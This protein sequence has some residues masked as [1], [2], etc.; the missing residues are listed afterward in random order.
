MKEITLE[1][2]P[3]DL[4]ETA[5]TEPEE[6]DTTST[7]TEESVL[8]SRGGSVLLEVEDAEDKVQE[9]EA[10][11]RSTGSTTR[12]RVWVPAG[13]L[14][15]SMHMRLCNYRHDQK[16]K[17]QRGARSSGSS[18]KTSLVVK[19]PTTKAPSHKA[20]L[21]KAPVIPQPVQPVKSKVKKKSGQT[22]TSKLKSSLGQ[23]LV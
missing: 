13:I 12:L 11:P 6:A 23:V 4:L 10:P 21:L 2:A 14:V 9:V 19:A 22:K 17:K 5:V 18:S 1:E 20:P 3:K 7:G 16:M 15:E 8:F